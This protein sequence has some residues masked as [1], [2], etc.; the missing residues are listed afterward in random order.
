MWK[1]DER[2]KRPA[3]RHS[4]CWCEQLLLSLFI[5]SKLRPL[6]HLCIKS[7]AEQLMGCDLRCTTR[8]FTMASGLQH[9]AVSLSFLL[10]DH[11]AFR[12]RNNSHCGKIALNVQITKTIQWV[13]HLYSAQSLRNCSVW[14]LSVKTLGCF[15]S[16]ATFWPFEKFGT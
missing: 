8:C 15:Y 16:S 6:D 14:H 2:Q 12:L 10:C 4:F 7:L 5:V 1:T 9:E 3:R 11:R 13:S